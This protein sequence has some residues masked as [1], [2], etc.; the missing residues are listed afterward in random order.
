[1]LKVSRGVLNGARVVD[2]VSM[3]RYGRLCV[4]VCVL[5]MSV[6]RRGVRERC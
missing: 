3:Y 6:K 4:F 1:M 2:E 5:D